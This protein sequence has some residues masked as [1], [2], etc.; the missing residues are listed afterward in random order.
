[1]SL[2]VPFRDDILFLEVLEY[3]GV[4]SDELWVRFDHADLAP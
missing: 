4:V 1:M 2:N 3:I